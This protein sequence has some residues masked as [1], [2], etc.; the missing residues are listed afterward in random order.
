MNTAIFNMLFRCNKEFGHEKI[1]R[2]GLSDT[3]YI[4]CSYVMEHVDCTQEEVSTTLK[5]D[6]TTV[7]KAVASLEEKKCITR[8]QDKID[9]RKK[10]LRLTQSGKNKIS[11][12]MKIHDE[13]FAEI[14]TCLNDKEQAQFES[15]CEKILVRAEEMKDNMPND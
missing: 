4:I 2:K 3:E 8:K 1:R 11:E 9:R 14:M 12:L 7:G 13:W 15:F 5:I 10:H 6:K